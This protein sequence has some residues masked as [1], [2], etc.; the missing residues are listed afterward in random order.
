[1]QL[2]NSSFGWLSCVFFTKRALYLLRLES[3]T[4]LQLFFFFYETCMITGK[5]YKSYMT[6]Y[7]YRE[8]WISK[9]HR[10]VSLV[11]FL[12]NERYSCYD[13]SGLQLFLFFVWNLYDYREIIQIIYDLAWLPGII[14]DLVWNQG[15]LYDGQPGIISEC[16]QLKSHTNFTNQF[17]KS[18]SSSQTTQAMKKN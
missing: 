11:Y 4:H 12:P 3:L 9:T 17:W 15:K 10:W 6:L 13:Y 8:K 16:D 5:T 1:M 18:H 14:Y 2:K 7:D